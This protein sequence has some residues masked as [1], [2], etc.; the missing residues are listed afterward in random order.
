MP[1]YPQ[2]YFK[3]SGDR[4]ASLKTSSSGAGCLQRTCVNLYSTAPSAQPNCLELRYASRWI[5]C[6]TS[7]ATREWLSVG[8][9]DDDPLA[10]R[11][12]YV[13]CLCEA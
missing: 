9:A 5:G 7:S 3:T 12:I 6:A 13:A 11:I 2:A 10:D 8:L 1:P 4:V